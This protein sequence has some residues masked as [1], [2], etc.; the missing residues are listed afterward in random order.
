MRCDECGFDGDA[1]ANDDLVEA[2]ARFAK[3]YRTP[4]TRFLPGEDGPAM[5]RRRPSPDVWSAL[6]Y[7]AH[8]RDVFAFYRE[9]IERILAEDRPTLHAVGFGRREEERTYNDEDPAATADG[10]SRE[11]TAVAELLAGLDEDGWRRVGLA[12]DGSGDERTVRVLAERVVHDAHHHLL[13]IGR[14]LRAA[15]EAG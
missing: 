12:S 5:V 3:R 1:M 2:S 10:V 7:A 6:E 8:T 13:D 14:S 9:R 15:R 11:A 4:L